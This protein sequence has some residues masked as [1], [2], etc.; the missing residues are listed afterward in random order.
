MGSF[1]ILKEPRSHLEFMMTRKRVGYNFMYLGS[2]ALALCLFF[3]NGG[4]Q[5]VCVGSG[6]IGFALVVVDVVLAA[7]GKK[8]LTHAIWTLLNLLMIECEKFSGD[9]YDGV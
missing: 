6:I 3:Y 2:M 8:I 7:M 9:L 4:R 1:D 5:G